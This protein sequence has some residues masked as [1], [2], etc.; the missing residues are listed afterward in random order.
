M[1]CQCCDA[2]QHSHCYGFALEEPREPHFC[3]QCLV[4]ESDRFRLEK[5][6]SLA[7]FRRALWIVYTE[8]YPQ[9]E[10]AFAQRLRPSR[11]SLK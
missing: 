9:L 11:Y 7:R 1:Q 5:L 4:P 6:K 2:K 10:T 8:G 3:Y